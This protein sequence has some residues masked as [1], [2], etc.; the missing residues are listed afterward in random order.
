MPWPCVCLL[1]PVESPQQ[2]LLRHP[3]RVP[4]VRRMVALAWQPW[5]HVISACAPAV[6]HNL[7][8]L[9]SILLSLAPFSRRKPLLDIYDE[10]L[11]VESLAEQAYW[12]PV[13]RTSYIPRM[14]DKKMHAVL[15]A[16]QHYSVVQACDTHCNLQWCY[17]YDKCCHGQPSSVSYRSCSSSSSNCCCPGC[18]LT[19]HWPQL[20]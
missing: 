19:W 13:R 11:Q 15:T 3:G 12:V 5:T 20:R 6:Q 7:H 4:S 17:L 10:L 14:L 8:K 18:Q 2:F 1:L 9:G 16:S